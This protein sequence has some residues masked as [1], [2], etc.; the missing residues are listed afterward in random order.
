MTNAIYKC[1]KRLNNKFK[2]N[3]QSQQK[4][5]NKHDGIMFRKFG[6]TQV[7]NYHGLQQVGF[8]MYIDVDLYSSV[9]D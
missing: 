2:I 7:L 5:E 6:N 1:L 3:L 9:F 8:N 4:R